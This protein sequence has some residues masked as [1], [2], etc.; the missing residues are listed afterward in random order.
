M[1]YSELSNGNLKSFC[2][3]SKIYIDLSESAH[4][5]FS[6]WPSPMNLW[7]WTGTDSNQSHHAGSKLVCSST[8]G[9]FLGYMHYAWGL[10]SLS[11]FSLRRLFSPFCKKDFWKVFSTNPR[12]FCILDKLKLS[13]AAQ[14]WENHKFL[15]FILKWNSN[16]IWF[17]TPYH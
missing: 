5:V 2:Y 10:L 13:C 16:I 14:P 3:V 6:F 8:F 15:S 7:D 17:C 12:C 1:L 4:S 11:E 9:I